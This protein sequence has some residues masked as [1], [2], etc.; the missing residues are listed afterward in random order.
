MRFA[1]W[2]LVILLVLMT[3]P[4]LAWS[5]EPDWN[6][7]RTSIGASTPEPAAPGPATRAVWVQYDSAAT[8]E[9]ANQVLDRVV[10][11]GF[12]TVLY[13]IG[14]GSVGYPSAVLPST[15][16]GVAPGYDPLAYL[17]QQG[18]A[19]GLAVQ[20]WYCPGY[21]IGS[22]DFKGRHPDWDIAT[23]SGGRGNIH[24]LNFSLPS[25]QR[26]VGDVVI[27]IAEKY[28]VDGIHLDYIRYPT[29]SRAL[30]LSGYLG[31]SD[32]PVTVQ[33]AYLRLK[34]SKPNVLLTAAVMDS[35]YRSRRYMQYWDKWLAGGYID[36][37]MPMAYF[38]PDEL[39]GLQRDMKEW[40]QLPHSER[41]VPGLSVRQSNDKGKLAP[42]T[43]GQ[44]RDQLA[45]VQQGGFAAFSIFDYEEL[46]PELVNALGQWATPPRPAR[47]VV[48]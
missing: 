14:G 44:L 28:A 22:S 3:F 11:A 21:S 40:K 36:W 8:P 45:I 6:D 47:S 18:H 12:D 25:V 16:D 17:V 39:G 41:I 37:V 9:K 4:P 26:L 1:Q 32:V 13:L 20:A 31:D 29:T 15:L 7:S 46:T 5:P 33:S 43:P 38:G 19:R 24:W 42:K 30:G 2:V 48:P 34:A 10:Q 27:E 35:Q 23:V